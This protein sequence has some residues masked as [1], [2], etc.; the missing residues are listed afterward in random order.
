[1]A[2][3]TRAEIRNI[4]GEACTEEIENRL[5]ALHLGVVDPLKDDLTKYKADAEKLPGVQ[6]ELDDLKAQGDGGYKAKYEA[7]HKAFWDYKANVDAEKTT[8]AKEKALETA[9]KKVGIADKRL[10]SVVRLCKGDGLLDKLQL[11]EK[12]TIKDSDKLETSLKESYSDYIVTTST[13]GANTPNPPAGNGGGGITAEAFKKMGY[14]ERLKLYKESPE[15]YA[16]LANN[17]GD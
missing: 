17:K 15:Q 2:K 3:F 1:M 12:G 11:D 4:L 6:K 10:Q 8:A 9:L 13:Q 14:A 16:E 7:E 5:V